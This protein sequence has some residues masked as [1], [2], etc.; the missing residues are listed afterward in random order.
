MEGQ[1]ELDLRHYVAVLRRRWTVVA[2]VVFLAVGASLALSFTATRIYSASADV[3]LVTDTQ[4]DSVFSDAPSVRIDPVRQ[5]ETQI[6]VMGSRPIANTANKKLGAAA[7][8]VSSVSIDGVGQTDVIRVTVESAEPKV[9]KRAADLYAET[10]VSTRRKQQVESLLAAGE[11]VQK[12]LTEIQGQLNGLDPATQAAEFEAL[13]AQFELFKQKLDQVQVDAA[14]KRGGAQV[15]APAVL[16]STPVKPKPAR[17][18]VVA[19]VLGFIF[20]VALAFVA[21]Y[22][23]D[24]VNAA[25]DVERYGNGLTVLAEVPNFGGRRDRRGVRVVTL[26]APNS[27]AAEAYRSL[28]TSL[29]IIG[30]RRPIQTIL[31]TSPMAAEGKSTT[32]AN[33]G[34]TMARAGRQVVIVDLDLRRPKQS[35]FFDLPEGPGFTSV[36]VGDVPLPDALTAIEVGS[37]IPALQVLPTGPLP[38][39]PSELMGTSRVAELITSLQ[40]FAD[41]VIIDSPPLIPVTDAMVVSS[42]VDGVLLVIGAGLTRRRHLARAVDLLQQ[43]EAPILGGLLNASTTQSRGYGYGGYR[44][45]SYRSEKS[46]LRRVFG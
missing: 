37:G 20:G 42:R 38:P 33:L 13:T 17:D 12:K 9:A 29:Q 41:L 8:Q 16:P 30:L 32:V 21:E 6:E 31:V 26:E 19:A 35:E 18:G 11:E 24:K 7:S 39:N 45:G 3:L 46:G 40:S 15:V 5:V 4:Q 10:Y 27:A 34:V 36:L 44:Y 28:R 22:L 14:L 2:L 1:P 43:A 23:D 25:D